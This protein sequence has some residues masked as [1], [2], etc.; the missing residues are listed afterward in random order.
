MI[1]SLDQLPDNV[2]LETDVCVVGTGAAGL[3]TALEFVD[4]NVPV[5]MLE[6]G[7]L[8]WTERA[9]DLYDGE[10]RDDAFR[11]LQQGRLIDAVRFLHPSS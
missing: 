2:L 8:H 9:Q 11:G 5:V 6:G 3:I 1:S 10:V 4:S 7:D